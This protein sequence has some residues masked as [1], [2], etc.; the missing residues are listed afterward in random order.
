MRFKQVSLLALFSFV[1]FLVFLSGGCGGSSAPP[2]LVFTSVPTSNVTA[3]TVFTA[4]VQVEDSGG[5]VMTSSTASITLAPSTGS[6]AEG[7]TATVSAVNGVATFSN[8]M[9]DTAGTFTLTATS[10]GLTGGTSGNITVGPVLTATQLVF[11]TEPPTTGT[12]GSAFHATV[13]IEDQFGN[14]ETGASTQI[15]LTPSPSVAWDPSSGTNVVTVTNG[16]ANFTNMILDAAGSYTFTATGGGLTSLASSSITISAATANKLVWNPQPV[17]NVN[18]GVALSTQPAV[19]VEDTYGNPV[20]SGLTVNLTLYD[21]AGAGALSCTNTSVT[22][23]TSTGIATFANCAVSGSGAY[24]L[25]AT[26][27]GIALSNEPASNQITINGPDAL[28]FNPEPNAPLTAGACNAFTINA[29]DTQTGFNTAPIAAL[30]VNL[31]TGHAGGTFYSA[32]GCTGTAITSATIPT[33]PPYS[34]TVFYQDTTLTNTNFTL[35]ASTTTPPMSPATSYQYKVIA[36]TAS[37]LAITSSAFTLTAGACSSTGI[38]VTSEDQYGNVSNVASTQESIS[39]GSSSNGAN[40]YSPPSGCTGTVITGTAIPIGSSSATFYYSDTK[41]GTPTITVSGT[42]EFTSSGLNAEKQTET[43]NAGAANKLVWSTQPLSGVNP[44]SSIGT[45]AVE[46]EDLNGNPILINPPQVTLAITSGTGNTATGVALTCSPNPVTPSTTTGIATFN[47]CSINASSPTTSPYTLTATASGL[48]SLPSSQVAISGPIQLVFNTE[49]TGPLTAGACNSLLIG[50][51]NSGSFANATSNLTV[52]LTA[53]GGSGAFY[54]SISG[55]GTCTTA[56]TSTTIGIGTS[57]QQVYYEDNKATTSSY[58]LTAATSTLPGIS[59]VTTP[60]PGYTVVAGP[61]TTLVFTTQPGGGQANSAW[62]TQPAVTVEDSYGNPITSGTYAT[63]SI[64][65]AITSP[66]SGTTLTCTQ[67]NN[68]MNAALGV[69]Q[70]SG[71]QINTTGS[72]TLTASAMLSGGPATVNSSTVSISQITIRTALHGWSAV[73][74]ADLGTPYNVQLAASGGTGPYTWSATGSNLSTYELS[75]SATGLISGTSTGS[76]G[77]IASFTAVATDSLGHTGQQ[78][79]SITMYGTPS[80]P[81]ADPASL[82]ANGYT[83]QL[84]SGSIGGVGGTGDLTWSVTGLNGTTG[85][86]W[87]GNQTAN[88]G[89]SISITGTPAAATGGTVLTPNVTV[90][91][92]NADTENGYTLPSVNYTISVATWAAVALPAPSAT[93]PGTAYV[94]QPYNG[95]ITVNSGT[96]VPPYVWSIGGTQIG[97]SCYSLGDNICAT[98][99]GGSKL[100]FSGTPGSTPTTL[101][102]FT[103]KVVDSTTPTNSSAS[104]SSYTIVVSNASPLTVTVNAKDVPQGMVNMPYTFNSINVSGGNQGDVYTAVYTGQTG[105]EVPPGLTLGLDNWSLVGTPTSATGS[106]YSVSVTVTDT[107]TGATGSTTFSVSV[108]PETVAVAANTGYLKGKYACNFEQFWDAGSTSSSGSGNLYRGGAVLAFAA[109]GSG[110]ITGGEADHN[111]PYSGYQ[112]VS[113]LGGYYAVGSDNRGYLNLTKV[114]TIFA[115][116]GGNLNASGVFSEF[117][118]TEMDDAGTSPAGTHGGGRCYLQTTASTLSGS[119]AFGFRDESDDGSLG[120]LA[121][122]VDFNSTTSNV[123]GEADQ[124][125]AGTFNGPSSLS[126]TYTKTVDSYGRTTMT[127]GPSQ[128]Q[129]PF[130][131]YL[132]NNSVG[133]MLIMTTPSHG[134][135][136]LTGANDFFIGEARAQ[137]SVPASSPLSGPFVLYMSGPD[138]CGNFKATVAQMST[139][140]YVDLENDNKILTVSSGSSPRAYTYPAGSVTSRG[141]FNPSPAYGADLFY[142]YNTNSAVVL[143]ADGQESG[144]SQMLLGWI[145]P[146]TAPTGLWDIGDMSGTSGTSYFIG[147]LQNWNNSVDSQSGT[148]TLTSSGAMSPFAQDDG[149]QNWASWDYD[150]TFLFGEPEAGSIALDANYGQHGVFDINVTPTGGTPTTITDCVA[151]SVDKA[152][153]SSTKGRFACVNTTSNGDPVI[154]IGQE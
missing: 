112:Y 70:F 149:D 30:N 28:L 116:A 79:L 128:G 58:Q 46:V 103:V 126:G 1:A 119:Y 107:T 136:T 19:E 83:T 32:G 95:S 73:P 36:G 26:A 129:S 25:T 3:G 144:E 88:T 13:T 57:Q 2:K 51:E 55:S 68:T 141:T 97:S 108:V 39:L 7:S 102:P 152:T 74:P 124:V 17:G 86:T 59:S 69:A 145:E 11:T 72:Y 56:I 64:A 21:V 77:N 62:S 71:C 81:I 9:M 53:S 105:S 75:L 38:T 134:N 37:Q 92:T 67:T 78:Y 122:Y 84:Y 12:A 66:P 135:G 151:I 111:S 125:K 106:P 131:V 80:L 87:I 34:V 76:Q 132:T 110:A 61:A 16:Q 49:P 40:F 63:A 5:N 60:N 146:Q 140:G 15:T 148:F 147:S 50:A 118:L 90:T 42:G 85:L 10:S 121:G 18:P 114:N 98:S 47:G 101:G 130:V 109:N 153:N 8:L 127:I 82:P 41:A 137:K 20:L 123:T 142:V 113:S 22:S 29:F 33:T 96:G 139:N 44:S 99:T 94:S 133:E 65:L 6:F 115:I 93:V 27:P 91:D 54:S 48:T 52:N 117:A 138:C 35:T 120:A 89:T 43:V 154:A 14:P 100:S 24:Q 31:A 45:P 4:V 150:F 143:F 104:N 23:S